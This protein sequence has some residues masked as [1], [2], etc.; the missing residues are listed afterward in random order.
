MMIKKYIINGLPCKTPSTVYPAKYIFLR[1][2]EGVICFKKRPLNNSEDAHYIY[3]HFPN[4][5][6]R[7]NIEKG[8]FD[9]VDTLRIDN[10]VRLEKNVFCYQVD[11]GIYHIHSYCKSLQGLNILE[12]D[13]EL[14]PPDFLKELISKDVTDNLKYSEIKLAFDGLP[15]D[16]QATEDSPKK[17]NDKDSSSRLISVT[18]SSQ[19]PPKQFKKNK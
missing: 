7:Y 17:D 11:T 9:F 10:K 4:G 1:L 3:L 6:V 19:F 14:S 18:P 12:Y 16:G 13:S 15:K 8:L 2:L 5:E